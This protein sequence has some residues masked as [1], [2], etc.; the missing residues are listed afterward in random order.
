[1]PK[2]YWQQARIRDI[3]R[4]ATAD[5]EWAEREKS[6]QKRRRGKK[7]KAKRRKQIKAQM[8]ADKR[9]QTAKLGKPS[10]RPATI[11]MMQVVEAGQR[12]EIRHAD[13]DRWQ[14][15]S[16]RQT[17]EAIVIG[18]TADYDELAYKD[19]IIRVPIGPQATLRVSGPK[20]QTG[21]NETR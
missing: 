17:I 14:S 11:K 20:P 9:L 16:T 2:D 3:Q 12:V 7:I 5:R 21:T 15:Y 6:R 19:W 10:P 18:G 4:R 1:M 8:V 13:G